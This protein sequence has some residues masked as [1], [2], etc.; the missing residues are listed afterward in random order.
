MSASRQSVSVM[1]TTSH[2]HNVQYLFQSFCQIL[3]FDLFSGDCR[4][5]W[6]TAETFISQ[7]KS[8]IQHTNSSCVISGLSPCY[9]PITNKIPSESRINTIRWEGDQSVTRGLSGFKGPENEMSTVRNIK[10]VKTNSFTQLL[11]SKLL[12]CVNHRCFLGAADNA[13]MLRQA[14]LSRWPSV[15]CLLHAVIIILGE[16]KKSSSAKV[17]F[18]NK[19]PARES[20]TTKETTYSASIFHNGVTSGL[21]AEAQKARDGTPKADSRVH[22]TVKHRAPNC[23]PIS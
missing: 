12:M 16:E 23:N 6:K 11:Q 15:A 13:V 19:L 21:V 1:F 9:Q 5:R 7:T 17:T 20:L 18:D 4:T 2:P 10:R 22:D 14:C 8:H 3:N